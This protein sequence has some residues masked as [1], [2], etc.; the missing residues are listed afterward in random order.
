MIVCSCRAVSDRELR[1]AAEAGCS[2]EEVVRT[3]GVTTDCGCC[4]DTVARLV[5]AEAAAACPNPC[6]GCP[7]AGS[8]P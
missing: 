3:T 5:H 8:S 4:I 1:S 2:L 6:P 7:R